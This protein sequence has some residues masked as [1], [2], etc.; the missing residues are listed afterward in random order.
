MK[1]HRIFAIVLRYT[2][3]FMHSFDRL[4]D[5]FYWP[6]LDLFVWGLTS[7]YFRSFMPV[8]SPVLLI[9]LSGIVLWLIVWRG[10]YEISV[11]LLEDLWNKN[12]VNIFVSPLK[13]SEWVVSF[14][15]IGF[16]KAV[17][18]LI[19][20]SF[21]A[22]LLYKF[23]IF[24]Y[25]F[26]IIPFFLLLILTGWWVG[27]FVAGIILRYGTRVQ[28]LAWVMVAAI[29]PFSAVYYPLSALPLW[30]QKVA[31]IIPTS[32]IFEGAREVIYKGVLD[33]RK[34]IIC[35]LLNIIYLTLSILFLK[36][37]FAKILEKGLIKIY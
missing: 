27:F 6:A 11:N 19:F 30:A 5:A 3:L 32:Y 21:L 26:Y 13:F 20:T 23:R 17:V 29:S 7:V 10:Q 25:G 37:S 1:I 2:Y 28:T 24:I 14:L 12:L 31:M 4:S 16:I 15:I 22:F 8:D 36:K 9:I 18:S 33:P 34:L 35:L